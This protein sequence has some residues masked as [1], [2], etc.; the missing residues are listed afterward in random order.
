MV[1]REERDSKINSAY[2][3]VEERSRLNDQSHVEQ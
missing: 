2:L 1:A 3:R